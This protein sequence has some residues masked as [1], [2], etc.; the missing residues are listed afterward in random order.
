MSGGCP[1]LLKVQRLHRW[2][3]SQV[4]ERYSI[5]SELQFECLSGGFG[6]CLALIAIWAP[7]A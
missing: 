2:T 6:V 3:D 7:A 4:P 5:V 1:F